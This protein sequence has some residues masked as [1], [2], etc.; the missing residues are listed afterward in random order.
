VLISEL[1]N[2]RNQSEGFVIEPRGGVMGSP[3]SDQYISEEPRQLAWEASTPLEPYSLAR[4]IASEGY[5]GDKSSEGAAAAV[6]ICQIVINESRRRGWS[7]TER[8]TYHVTEDNRC[9]RYGRQKGRYA[10]TIRDPKKWHIDV[11]QAAWS[12]A[13]ADI[14]NGAH[15]FFDPKAQDGGIQAGER[16]RRD[17][18]EV[19]REWIIDSGNEFVPIVGVSAYHLMGFRK[20][21]LP[22]SQRLANFE[23]A[24]AI[25]EKGRRGE[26]TKTP[27][28]PD[29]YTGM[30]V[31]TGITLEN[32]VLS[33]GRFLGLA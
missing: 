19:C 30:K 9:W 1:Q 2:R 20:S 3:A 33:V 5:S 21:N 22:K 23:Q 12:G 14:S 17:A 4:C 28:D 25:I 11:A 24:K 15:M 8:L 13:V 6:A 16:L 7:P 18:I 10:A 31:K 27:G 26:D 32:I 29:R